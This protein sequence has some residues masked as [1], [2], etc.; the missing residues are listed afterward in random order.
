MDL[1]LQTGAQDDARVSRMETPMLA[2]PFGELCAG[3]CAQGG[4]AAA[5][6]GYQIE[7]NKRFSYP[8]ACLVLMLVGV[9][10]GLSSKRGGKSTGFVLTILLVFLYYFFVVGGGGAGQAGEGVAV[11]GSVGGEPAICRGGAGAAAADVVRRG[12]AWMR[13]RAWARSWRGC[14]RV[15]SADGEGGRGGRRR[16]LPRRCC[17]ASAA[18]GVLRFRFPL[19]L[20]EY[21]MREFGPNFGL[22][23]LDV[24]RVFVIFTF[25]ELI[26]DIIRNRTPLVTVGDLP[27]EPDAVTSCTT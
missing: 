8:F 27:A 6:S 10:L 11:P 19:L 3:K 26:G 21:V 20:D 17:A 7:L 1:P 18:V 9:P 4:S 23:L 12:S 14:C 13:S 16:M 22:V 25:F 15:T 2:L 5:R 24:L